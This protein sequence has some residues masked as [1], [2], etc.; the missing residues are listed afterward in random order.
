LLL[1]ENEMTIS[2]FAPLTQLLNQYTVGFDDFV[3]SLNEDFFDVQNLT[4]N[5]PPYNIIRYDTNSFI[6]EMAV[7]GFKKENI[8]ITLDDN[9]L[10]VKGG[11]TI[12]PDEDGNKNT[13]FTFI[14]KGIANRAFEKK[15]KVSNDI[16]LNEVTLIDGLLTID[17]KHIDKK[18]TSKKITIK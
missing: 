6:L 5:F 18:E 2:K 8:D 11:F 14:H 16:E 3:N 9:T 15:F 12:S 13:L 4:S 17:F 7:A 1:G 10:T